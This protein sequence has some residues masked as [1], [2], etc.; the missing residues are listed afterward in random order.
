[1]SHFV[2]FGHTFVTFLSRLNCH[3]NILGAFPPF[4]MSNFHYIWSHFCH[5][6]TIFMQFLYVTFSL[7]LVTF[8][9]HFHSFCHIFNVFGHILSHFHSFCHIY[10]TFSLFMV[11]FCLYYRARVGHVFNLGYA[12][13]EKKTIINSAF[14]FG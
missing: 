6:F 14:G 2:L 12:L 10:V 7:Y 5:I 3:I 13:V 11:T 8:M 9:S 4:Y 1:M